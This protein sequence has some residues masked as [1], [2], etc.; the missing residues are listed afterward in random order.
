M[1]SAKRLG[2][3][4][5]QPLS[6]LVVALLAGAC[7]DSQLPTE[8]SVTRPSP[9]I[10]VDREANDIIPNSYIVVFDPALVK[11]VS[12]RRSL[13]AKLHSRS[14]GRQTFIYENLG[15]YAVEN[16]SAA[17]AAAI[18]REVGVAYVEPD[19]MMHNSAITQSSPGSRS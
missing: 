17:S 10:A 18:A 11:D 7:S 19:K 9:S 4:R 16:L 14:G 6:L 13:A 12:S 8:G 2:R 15:G 5:S 1:Q 3:S